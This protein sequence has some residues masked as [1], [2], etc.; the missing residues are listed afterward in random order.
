MVSEKDFVY[1]R[2]EDGVR[3]TAYTGSEVDVKIPEMLDQKPVR[4]IG[5]EAFS[6]ATDVERIV[7]PA[8][9]RKICHGAFKYC[10]ALEDVV[11]TEGVEELEDEIF[12]VTSVSKIHIPASV[13]MIHAPYDM[14]EFE[15][16]IAKD[17][18]YYK[19]DD[20]ALYKK[21]E[22]GWHM[23]AMHL[24]NKAKEY[25]VQ[26]GTVEIEQSAFSGNEILEKIVLPDSVRVIGPDAMESC[27]AL[28]EVNLPE[29][30]IRIENGA[31]RG[32]TN[33][34]EIHL[35]KSLTTLSVGAVNHTFN[36]NASERGFHKVT[37]EKGNAHFAIDEDALYRIGEQGLSLMWY[38]G[39]EKEYTIPDSVWR[40]ETGSFFR[41][42]LVK[43]TIPASVQCVEKGAFEHCDELDELVLKDCGIT[44]YI[45]KV[46]RYRRDEM[47]SFLL[48]EP[49]GSIYGFEQY[50]QAWDTYRI[51]E[52]KAKM[53]ASRL[54]DAMMLTS[55]N[56][57]KY[58]TYLQEHFAEILEDIAQ[59]AD[60]SEL[61]L[62]CDAGVINSENVDRAM[63]CFAGALRGE[64]SGML[65]EY[66][67]THLGY[68]SFDFSL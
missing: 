29:G 13:R 35:P 16:T 37:I 50:D 66:K 32:C 44:L 30:L 24:L 47:M 65:L 15:W 58:E 39:V 68:Q 41:G 63:E 55:Q 18:P 48:P 6:E 43:L 12:F 40:I 2:I 26:D 54:K 21:C 52:E 19:S 59:R 11:M 31:F 7:L 8:N 22:D 38:F 33:L 61:A 14:A 23:V 53:A 3:I 27:M 17:S 60:Q 56:R 25:R 57:E 45:P 34:K 36:W 64:L 4:Q 62:L 1:E 46:P 28:R 49:N 9:L 67:E 51:L 42:G 10:L 5:E 20:F